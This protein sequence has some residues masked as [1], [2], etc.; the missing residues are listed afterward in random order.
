MIT[1]ELGSVAHVP[2]AMR[3]QYERAV[4]RYRE[5]VQSWPLAVRE[6]GY[7]DH[8]LCLLNHVP[9]PPPDGMVLVIWPGEFDRV[10]PA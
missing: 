1:Q 2:P 3:D 6:A 5:L 7:D 10:V 8:P 4:R 9:E